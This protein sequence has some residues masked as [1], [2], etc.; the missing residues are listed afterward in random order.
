MI[1]SILEKCLAELS[2]ENADLSYIRGMIEVLLALQ[3]KPKPE[4][5]KAPVVKP[6]NTN[7]PADEAAILDAK[8]RAA[9]ETVKQLTVLE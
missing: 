9:I 4:E 7:D 5:P 6:T 8:A 3:D 2:K 1:Y